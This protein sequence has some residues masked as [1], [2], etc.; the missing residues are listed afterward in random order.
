MFLVNM[1]NNKSHDLFSVFNGMPTAITSQLVQVIE[2]LD[3]GMSKGNV[4]EFSWVIGA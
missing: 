2:L 4:F 1:N 3:C